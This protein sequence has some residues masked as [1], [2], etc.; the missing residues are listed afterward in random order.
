MCFPKKLSIFKKKP[1]GLDTDNSNNQNG[2]G[3][4]AESHVSFLLD[5]KKLKMIH[6]NDPNLGIEIDFNLQRSGG[7]I[8]NY[9]WIQPNI[10][11]VAFASGYVVIKQL[12][13][14]ALRILE[15][16]NATSRS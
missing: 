4:A 15:I 8:T 5:R 9:Q 3:P 14:E 7:Q 16:S 2:T 12:S 10:V 13:Q 1:S 11:A 6:A